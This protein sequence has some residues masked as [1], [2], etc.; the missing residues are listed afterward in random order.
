MP[1]SRS[2][3]SPW[4]K[5]S[6]LT[7]HAALIKGTHWLESLS[8]WDTGVRVWRQRLTGAGLGL[9]GLCLLQVP[10]AER[11]TLM[12]ALGLMSY[13]SISHVYHQA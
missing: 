2:K 10:K 8:P 3:Y 12:C 13:S 7:C 4:E 9:P 5:Q 6:S 1:C 11:G